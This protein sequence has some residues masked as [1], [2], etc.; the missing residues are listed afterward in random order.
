MK[1]R[2]RAK[3]THSQAG[4]PE[5]QEGAP[6]CRFNKLCFLFFFLAGHYSSGAKAQV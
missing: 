2:L 1:Q 6:V 5:M 4:L 3:N